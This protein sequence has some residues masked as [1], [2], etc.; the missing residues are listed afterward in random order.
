MGRLRPWAPSL[1]LLLLPCAGTST[2]SATPAFPPAPSGYQRFTGHCMSEQLCPPGRTCDCASP[3]WIIEFKLCKPFPS[4]CFAQAEAACHA[5]VNCTAFSLSSYQGGSLQLFRGLKNDSAVPNGDWTSYAQICDGPPSACRPAVPPPPSPV[6]PSPVPPGPPSPTPAPAVSFE[7]AWRAA[8]LKYGQQIQPAMRA[9]DAALLLRSLNHSH[10]PFP[11]HDSG[12]FPP[13]PPKRVADDH[14]MGTP[15]RSH[16]PIVL[17]AFAENA[18]QFHV[19]AT[20]RGSASSCSDG[21]LGSQQQP[22]CSVL[23]G[24]A[25]CRHLL[26]T[27][28]I[29]ACAV[30]LANGTHRLNATIEL[31]TADSGLAIV[32]ADAGATVSGASLLRGGG[33]ASPAWERVRSLPNGTSLWKLTVPD[34]GPAPPSDT[35]YVD[36]KRAIQARYPNADPEVD[37]FP[38][39]YVTKTPKEIAQEWV[40]PRSP[41]PVATPISYP[42]INRTDF[43]DEFTDFRGG[44]GGVCAHFSPPFSYWCANPL[45]NAGEFQPT[46]PAGLRYSAT[47]L[48]HSPRYKSVAGAVVTAWRSEHWANWAFEVSDWGNSSTPTQPYPAQVS[49]LNFSRGGFQGARG[50]GGSEWFISNLPEELDSD[51]EF[52]FNSSDQ[53]LLYVASDSKPPTQ[54]VFEHARLKQLFT[55]RGTQEKPATNIS[56]S[57][58]AFTG[59]L[60][61]FLDPHGVPS[62]GDW[63]LQR[64][65]AL[66]FE[67]T[68]RSV[69]ER[70]VLH[71]L[72]GNAIMFSAFNQHANISHN[73][74]VQ[75]GGTAIAFWGNSSG[76]HPAQPPGTGPDGTG[77]NFPRHNLVEFNFIT[78]LGIHAK[79]S[80]CFFQ[81]K[82]AQ[83][84]VRR[85]I[86]FDVPRAGFNLNDVRSTSQRLLHRAVTHL[87]HVTLR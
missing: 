27:G 10:F 77:G 20:D 23:A 40:P 18:A 70:C 67:G 9:V 32:G 24:V 36:G 49:E 2:L 11:D 25:G 17:A 57:G 84:T 5:A 35:L 51:R 28:E 39:G 78:Q 79:Q 19:A 12:C 50:G 73:T 6:P 13:P 83:T 15:L 86:C 30:V 33:G 87:T 26:S 85:N 72:D 46:V 1:V 80:S 56:F 47:S 14:S 82:S 63:S 64:S 58:L 34:Y 31:T 53:T 55:V 43:M 29:R 44:V 59:T 45:G 71:R 81:A 4:A 60:S 48:P 7:C 52:W 41:L 37:K 3:A 74:I 76:S 62:G 8:A 42:K 65:A 61:V 38:T 68:D 54:S 75:T 22:F 16:H 69:V 21:G 66:F